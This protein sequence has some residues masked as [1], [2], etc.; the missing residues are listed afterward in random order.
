MSALVVIVTFDIKVISLYV[1]GIAGVAVASDRSSR[2]RAMVAS[3]LGGTLI[4]LGLVLVKD[5]AA[6][7]TE[8]PWFRG[9]LEESGDS[10]A[11]SFLI[12]ALLMF[13]MQSSSA[14]MIFGISLA[15]VDLLS[16]DQAIMIMYG[17]LVGLGATFYCCRRGFRAVRVRC[18]CAWW[19]QRA[20]LRG[21][22]SSPVY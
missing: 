9:L 1:L 15:A 7:L 14:V 20:H 10:L 12:A 6:P 21:A 5:A 13:A 11:V 17:S 3:F 2:F 4:I 19:V 18:R 16:V 8:Q 22:G